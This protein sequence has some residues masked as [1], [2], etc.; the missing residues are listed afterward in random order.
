[1]VMTRASKNSFQASVKE[2]IA[3]AVRPGVESGSDPHSTSLVPEVVRRF[4]W[5]VEPMVGYPYAKSS[6]KVLAVPARKV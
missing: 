3:E 2:N 6:G 4:L 1:M 5:Q